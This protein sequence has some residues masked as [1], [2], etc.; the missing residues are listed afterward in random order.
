MWQC[1][2]DFQ[3]YC[4]D[5]F[6]WLKTEDDSLEMRVGKLEQKVIEIMG[7][8]ADLKTEFEAYKANVDARAKAQADSIA[9]L[10]AKLAALPPGVDMTALQADLQEIKDANAAL[11]APA[12]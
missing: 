7:I 11:T 12:S 9:A 4:Y 8:E 2:S 6:R 3:K 5:W 1:F 10:D